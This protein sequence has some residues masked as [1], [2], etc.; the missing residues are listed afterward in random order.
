MAVNNKHIQYTSNKDDWQ[1]MRDVISSNVGGYVPKLEGQSTAEFEAYVARPAF[2][3]A[4]TRT[5]D[6]LLGLIY[7]KEP[8]ITDSTELNRI[9][10]NITLDDD[11]LEDFS[12]MVSKE[13]LSVGRCGVLID[14]PSIDRSQFSASQIESMNL[15]TYARLYKTENII[16][17]RYTNVN[18]IQYLSLLVLEESFEYQDGDEFTTKIGTQWRVLDLFEGRYRQRIYIQNNKDIIFSGEVLPVANG[19]PISYIPFVFF[20]VN[21][22][23]GI[24]E[25][26]PLLDLAKVNLSH[27]KNDVDLEHGAH[28][29]ALP[30]PCISG[31]SADANAPA[32]KIGSTSFLT[33]DNPQAK[34]YYLEFTGGGLTTIQSI[35]ASKEKRMAVL[36]ARLLLDEKKTA[37]ATETVAMRSSGERAVLVNISKTISSGIKKVLEIIAEWENIKQEIVYNLN[38]DYNLN[39]IDPQLLAQ[40]MGGVQSGTIPMEVL[41]HNM[42]EGELIPDDMDFETYQSN[43]ETATPQM[44]VSSN[45]KA[46]MTKLGM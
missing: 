17:W 46:L 20:G 6:A 19:N 11:T 10:E 35:I 30:T 22:L 40:I 14:M 36:G 31:Y 1:M 37:E 44:S 29:T 27:F 4:T 24:V 9:Y 2:F 13:V 32:I 21:E 3:N 33:F 26:P 45:T 39:T 28:F 38:T 41:F 12:K 8:E 42:K 34:A 43:I 5:L 7:S 18:G 23:K 15:R 25:A 16:N